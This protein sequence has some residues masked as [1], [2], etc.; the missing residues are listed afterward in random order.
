MLPHGCQLGLDD[1]AL[2][3]VGQGA[4]LQGD[5]TLAWDGLCDVGVVRVDDGAL[6]HAVGVSG[7]VRVGQ[8][9]LVAVLQR[10]QIPEH[11]ITPGAGETQAMASDIDVG[12]P[13]PGVPR[14]IQVERPVVERT[15]IMHVPRVDGHAFY[16]P[17]LGD[18]QGHGRV[19]WRLLRQE[20]RAGEGVAYEEGVPHQN[21]PGH[22]E[23]GG[24][25][26]AKYPD[27]ASSR[28]VGPHLPLF[29]DSG[30]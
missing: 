1:Q 24:Y 8:D 5:N 4:R 23:Q 28:P 12:P 18:G 26:V 15:L 10:V 17:H 21:Q 11:E 25:V 3:I 7:T 27:P 6:V 13:L 16:T 30:L 14:A 9:N 2:R 29:V 19:A 22:Y 20:G